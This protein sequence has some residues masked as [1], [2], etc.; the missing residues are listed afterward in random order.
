[1][2]FRQGVRIAVSHLAALAVIGALSTT[3]VFAQGRSFKDQDLKFKN[4]AGQALNGADFTGAILVS[5]DFHGASLKGAKFDGAQLQNT[6]FAGADLTGADMRN[7]YGVFSMLF[8]NGADF[9]QINMEGV[10]LKG[11]SFYGSSGMFVGAIYNDDTI[12]PK[13][14]D[15]AQSGAKKTP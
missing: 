2:F 15:V 9:T 6:N 5:T 10:D 11:T 4:L 3:V 8:A 7:V 12:W 14:F 1:M 13:W